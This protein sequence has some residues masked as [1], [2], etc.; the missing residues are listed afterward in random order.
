MKK[1]VLLTSILALAA[2]GGGSGG[3][4]G[5]VAPRAAIEPDSPV[6]LSNAQITSMASE[7]LVASDG[8]AVA[9]SMTRSGSAIFNGQRYTSYRLDDVQFKMGGEDSLVKFE[10]DKDGKII[11]LGK[12]DRSDDFTGDPEYAISEEGRFVRTGGTGNTFEKDLYR[13]TYN[14]DN[15]DP[16]I[17]ELAKQHFKDIDLTDDNGSLSPAQLKA[18]LIAKVTKKMNKVIASQSPD[19]PNYA[20]DVQALRDSLAI[21][22]SQ[23][24]NTGSFD[25]P[26]A[27]H[28]TLQVQGVNNATGLKYADFGFAELTIR[29]SGDNIVSHLFTPY[30]G[31]YS[32]VKVDPSLLETDGVTFTGTVIAGIDHKSKISGVKTEEGVLVRQDNA[33]LT[34][35]RNGSSDLVM[36]NLVVND[37]G[38]NNGKHWY[39]VILHTDANG[40][41]T[42]EISGSS[43]IGGANYNL[44]S[45]ALIAAAGGS[46]GFDAGDWSAHDQEYVGHM[47]DDNGTPADPSDDI[48]HRF[49]GVAETTLYG[50]NGDATE[51]TTKFGFGNE[52]HWNNNADHNEVAIYGAFGG[53]KD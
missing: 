24:N 52:T 37:G 41:P 36:D 35:N 11:A 2:C 15:S 6:A 25:T 10:L 12:Y 5:G 43:N 18:K 34:M 16:G 32:A 30:V 20:N 23:I 3:G 8:S 33:V 28:A 42:F 21:Y 40:L 22:I 45:A 50:L 46:V 49:S 31:G 53:K 48:G 39:E 4:G 9:P 14:F 51:A 38:A 27:G 47:E 44:P 13:Y 1:Y 26:F 17:S 19:N 29:D 7:I